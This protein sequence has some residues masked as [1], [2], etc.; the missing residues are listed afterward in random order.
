MRYNARMTWVYLSPH[1]DDAAL[2]CGGLIW[3]QT[4]ASLKTAIWTVCAGDP[5]PGS[6]SPFAQELHSRWQAEENAPARRKIEDIS[7]CLRLGSGY[8]HFSIPDCIYRRNPQTG[9]F[10]YA[11]EAALNGFLDQGDTCIIQELA[12]ELL[13]AIPAD[14][15]VVCPLALGSHVDH[16]L[17]RLAAEQTGLKLC[18]YT[19]FPYV[20]R[21]QAQLE[22]MIAS[23]WDSQ[24]FPVSAE[25]LAAWQE[26]IRAHRSQI[27]TFWSSDLEMRQAI[28]AYLKVVGGIRLWSHPAS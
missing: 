14:T 22:Q 25:G 26:S 23:G 16:Q 8:R 5:P 1:F 4:R 11:Q 24:T 15:T 7:S 19:D 3:E 9:A 2:S 13:A 17:T 21:S 27:S 12:Q 18:Y 28:A 10:M 20:L 6:L